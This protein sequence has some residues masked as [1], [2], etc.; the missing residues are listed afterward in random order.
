MT[1]NSQRASCLCSLS[2]EINGIHRQQLRKG[3]I[4]VYGFISQSI[5]LGSQSKNL[6]AELMQRP[7]RGVA[8]WL[9]LHGLLN[10]LSF[11]FFFNSLFLFCVHWYF[12]STCVCVRV[13]GTGV[14]DSCELP[15]GYWELNPSPLEEQPVFL[16]SV[17]FPQPQ[18]A[19]LYTQPKGDSTHSGSG[20]LTLI[21]NLENT[22]QANLVE[23]FFLTQVPFS[24]MTLACDK[25][26]QTKPVQASTPLF[27][28]QGFFMA[29]LAGS[30]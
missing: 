21:T 19:F 17:L 4:S 22:P 13:S 20:P 5:S 6:E 16:F 1:L 11:F 26:T 30:G 8:Y 25:S 27:V 7:W 24:Q 2:A 23:T 14:T 18:S 29:R 9:A 28:R 3:F 12:A 15:C 10:L